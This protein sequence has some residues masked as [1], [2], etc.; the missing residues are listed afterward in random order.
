MAGIIALIRD[1]F[2]MTIAS[3]GG[4]TINLG[5]I[6]AGSVVFALGVSIFKR[7]KGR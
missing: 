5:M 3:L 1:V 2:D 4:T 6:A 7:V